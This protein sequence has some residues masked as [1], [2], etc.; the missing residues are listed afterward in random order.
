MLN[1]KS[2][3]TPNRRHL[4]FSHFIC[5]PDRFLHDSVAFFFLPLPM[6]FIYDI[7]SHLFDS[8][9]LL[10]GC[11]LIGVMNAFIRVKLRDFVCGIFI[12]NQITLRSGKIMKQKE[13]VYIYDYKTEKRINL[14]YLLREKVSSLHYTSAFT[15]IVSVNNSKILKTGG[16]VDLRCFVQKNRFR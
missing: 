13:N 6:A 3:L 4:A 10:P 16:S 11:L 15:L 2:I 5:L 1:L 7:L 14:F 12:S 9:D 8:L